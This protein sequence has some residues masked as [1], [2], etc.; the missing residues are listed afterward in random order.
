MDIIK[1]LKKQNNFDEKHETTFISNSEQ[2]NYNP[3]T[4][5]CPQHKKSLDIICETCNFMK[6]CS[7]CALFATHKS[8][9]LCKEPPA[10]KEDFQEVE[11]AFLIIK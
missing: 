7:H 2:K 8:H 1:N 10:S 5:M 11:D 6:I 4:S 9:K 3:L